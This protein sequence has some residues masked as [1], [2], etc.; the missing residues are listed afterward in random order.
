MDEE[1][2]RSADD[3]RTYLGITKIILNKHHMM[4][5]SREDGQARLLAIFAPNE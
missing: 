4:F 5:F 3:E 2:P 1:I